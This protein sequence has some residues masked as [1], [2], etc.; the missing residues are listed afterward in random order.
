MNP[1]RHLNSNKPKDTFDKSQLNVSPKLIDETKVDAVIVAAGFSGLYQ[2]YS[3][4][5]KFCIIRMTLRTGV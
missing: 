3:L 2:L 1:G 4:K 5:K